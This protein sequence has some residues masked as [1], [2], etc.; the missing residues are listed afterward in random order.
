MEI[1]K[2]PEIKI[3]NPQIEQIKE[4]MLKAVKKIKD[5][6]VKEKM[7]PDYMRDLTYYT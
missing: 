3:E 6:K 2:T 7:A 5:Q 1:K 4:K